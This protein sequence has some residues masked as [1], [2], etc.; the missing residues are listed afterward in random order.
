MRD[1]TLEFDKACLELLKSI[2]DIEVFDSFARDVKKP[3]YIVY[4]AGPRLT[5][6]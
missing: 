5:G 1:R 2:R 3:L 6:T 4:H